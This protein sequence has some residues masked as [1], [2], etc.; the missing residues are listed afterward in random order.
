M[1]DIK[2]LFIY[3]GISAVVI[4]F[5]ATLGTGDDIS[6]STVGYL[7]LLIVVVLPVVVAVFIAKK[8]RQ[9]KSE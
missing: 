3:G 8:E 4:F 2:N 9:S 6:G 5:L 1:K 7:A